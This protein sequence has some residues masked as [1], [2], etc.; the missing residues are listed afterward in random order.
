MS[1]TN[2]LKI[3]EKESNSLESRGINLWNQSVCS[4]L[5]A[6]DLTLLAESASDLQ[7]QMVLLKTYANKW[8]LEI[9]IT[10]MKVLVLKVHS[11]NCGKVEMYLCAACHAF[12][13]HINAWKN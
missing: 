4:M 12:T 2:I 10:K 9:N 3:S 13:P 6:D 11:L 8:N 1:F 7:M 5:Y